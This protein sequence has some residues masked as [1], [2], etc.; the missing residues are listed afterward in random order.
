MK[1]LIYCLL[2][3]LVF[4]TSC[5]GQVKTDSPKDDVGREK[6]STENH[7]K[8]VRAQ[9]A[10]YGNLI[11]ELKDRDGDLWFSVDGEGVYRFDGKSFT[12]FTSEDGLCDNATSTII[13]TKSGNI[14]I[15]THAGIC[16][17]DGKVFCRYFETD[18]LNNLRITALLEDRDGNIWFAAMNKGVYRYDGTNITNIL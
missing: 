18:T 1:K 17:Y 13:Q 10:T 11:C 4:V 9:G 3:L 8:I 14:L 5:D 6:S 12:N 16:K 2:L 7:A 15:G